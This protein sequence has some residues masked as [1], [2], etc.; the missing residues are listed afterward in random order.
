MTAAS[1]RP[2]TR[3]APSRAPARVIPRPSPAY[4]EQAPT[5]ELLA[6]LA[7]SRPGEPEWSTLRAELCRRHR[8]L[9][10][11][12]AWRFRDRGEDLDDLVQVGTVGLLHAID[13]FDPQ[14]G[15]E[16][17]TYATPTIVGEL[18]HHLRDRAGT[19]RVPRRLQERHAAVSAASVRL[20]QRLG[21]SP[22]VH[23]L[24]EVTDLTDE[25]VL[26][27]LEV[28]Q[29]STTIPL[30]GSDSSADTAALDSADALA[31]VENRAALRPLLDRLPPRDKRIIVLRFFAH[32][33]QSEIAAELGISQVQVSRLLTR[34]LT[35]LRTA[36]AD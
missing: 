27:A 28:A 29:A 36:L 9:V 14:C 32:R 23:E 6:R 20:Y 21:R 11:A 31:G 30:D 15:A 7:R 19:V 33:T 10:R 4:A 34:T 26:E 13:R 5:A 2:S 3:T 24:A 25:E 8:S 16:F 18:K 12:L 1:R 35:T 17:T 22:T